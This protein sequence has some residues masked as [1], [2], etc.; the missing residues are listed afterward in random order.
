MLLL[1]KFD[2]S[3]LVRDLYRTLAKGIELTEQYITNEQT[4]S[5]VNETNRFP[6]G[7]MSHL[8]GIEMP[9]FKL[10]S[11]LNEDTSELRKVEIPP[12]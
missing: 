10:H 12:P 5:L 11:Y 8:V 7:S 2:T 9:G 4:S 1:A 3:L 6:V